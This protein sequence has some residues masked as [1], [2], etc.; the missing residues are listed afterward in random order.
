MAFPWLFQASLPIS[1]IL[2][3]ICDFSSAQ[4]S[5]MSKEKNTSFSGNI[6]AIYEACMGPMLFEPYAIKLA[7]LIGRLQ[8]S[9]VLELACGTGRLTSHLAAELPASSAIIAT[10]VNSAMI[11]CARI[12]HPLI[13]HVHWD[14]VDAMELP[15]GA[16]QFNCVA[17][18]FGVMFYKDK[19]KAFKETFRVLKKGG[20]FIFSAWDRLEKNPVTAMVQEVAAEF[21]PVDTPA[22]FH[23]P[24][25]YY[26]ENVIKNDLNQA[27][28]DKITIT[29]FEERGLLISAENASKGFLEGSPMYHAIMERAPELLPPMR[30]RLAEALAMKFGTSFESPLSAFI[31]QAQKH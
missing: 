2:T 29:P 5:V 12:N 14:I 26:D 28:F 22:F 11:D 25:S 18:Q 24:H 31:V 19:V 20:T 15:Y 10:D 9:Q 13:S 3:L 21:F 23:I 17:A 7:A 27:G 8:P 16:G 1:G 6:P 30:K 4:S